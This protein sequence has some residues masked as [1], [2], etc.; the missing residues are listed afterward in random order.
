MIAE[1]TIA[2]ALRMLLIGEIF[3]GIKL[4]TPF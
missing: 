3:P 1:E 4:A 2:T